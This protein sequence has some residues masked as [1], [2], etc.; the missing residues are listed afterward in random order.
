MEDFVSL[1]LQ[2]CGTTEVPPAYNRW[3]ALSLLAAFAEDR[4]FGMKHADQKLTPNLYVTLV[5]GAGVGRSQAIRTATD[6]A[7]PLLPRLNVCWG[8][9]RGQDL[10]DSLGFKKRHGE[11][12]GHTMIDAGK[13]YLVSDDI[14]LAISRGIHAKPF[15]EMMTGLYDGVPVSVPDLSGVFSLVKVR[16]PCINWLC[17]TSP[18]WLVQNVSPEAISAGFFAQTILIAAHYQPK[19]RIA[20]PSYPANRAEMIAELRWRLEKIL[21][22]R[23]AL[24]PMAEDARAFMR[25]WYAERPVPSDAMMMPTWRRLQ[26][27]VYKVAILLALS[28]WTA[29]LRMW[30]ESGHGVQPV[31]VRTW[32]LEE[33]IAL[34]EATH[35]NVHDFASQALVTPG[36][37]VLHLIGN[38][39]RRRGGV[40][41]KDVLVHATR[42]RIRASALENVLWYLRK[43]GDIRRLQKHGSR[44]RVWYYEWIGAPLVAGDQFTSTEGLSSPP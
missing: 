26:D 31:V 25:D 10:I 8:K 42:H 3:A 22:I 9:L 43:N 37:N 38:F 44:N 28:E 6:L 29:R 33:A 1:Y 11:A 12:P 17:G 39:I 34:L 20:E 30:S 16:S 18:E 21:A 40:Y 36:Q 32:H 35:A 23:E 4:V 24:V 13:I 27:Q 41:H 14:G 7:M 15:V 2:H 5:G 19:L